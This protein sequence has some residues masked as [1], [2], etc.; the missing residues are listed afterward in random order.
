[1][2]SSPGH[3]GR[4]QI[5]VYSIILMIIALI[6]VLEATGYLPGGNETPGASNPNCL[7]SSYLSRNQ[8]AVVYVPI[9]ALAVSPQHSGT[10][11][12]GTFTGIVVGVNSSAFGYHWSYMNSERVDITGLVIDP[13]PPYTFYTYGHPPADVDTGIRVSCDG[14]R[15]WTVL[16]TRPDPHQWV[17]SESNS[18]VMYATDYPS[19]VMVMSMDGGST[20][21]VLSAPTLVESIAVSPTDDSTL[22]IGTE[23]GIYMSTDGGSTWSVASDQTKGELVTAICFLPESPRVA[24]AYAGSGTIKSVDGGRTWASISRGPGVADTILNMSADP[25]NQNILYASSNDNVYKTTD[26][27]ISWTLIGGLGSG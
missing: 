5:L 2:Q 1:M 9:R 17:L 6:G 11:Y 13:N 3:R 22:L 23:N 25:H 24:Y 7:S 8:S 10:L 4:N 14:A 21:K 20:W 26:G 27:G 12:L 19:N 18:S 16:T 15:S